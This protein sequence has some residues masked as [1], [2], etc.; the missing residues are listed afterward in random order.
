MLKRE[1]PGNS[2]VETKCRQ[3]IGSLIYAVIGTRADL[4]CAGMFISRFQ[5]M[6]SEELY[7]VLKRILRYLKETI[8]FV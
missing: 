6:T 7:K 4:S 1:K 3:L 8:D 5:N 2:N